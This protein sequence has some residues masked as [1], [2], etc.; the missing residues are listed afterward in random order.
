MACYKATRRWTA[1][2]KEVSVL[3]FLD[4]WGKSMLVA[5]KW[6]FI[7]FCKVKYFKFPWISAGRLSILLN[8]PCWTQRELKVVGTLVG[9]GCFYHII[10]CWVVFCTA[11]MLDLY[12]FQNI[13]PLPTLWPSLWG[14]IKCMFQVKHLGVIWILVNKSILIK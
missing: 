10:F 1:W 12:I 2:G 6:N 11:I 14:Y 9:I 8:F 13:T 5:Y 3:V 4:K 7:G